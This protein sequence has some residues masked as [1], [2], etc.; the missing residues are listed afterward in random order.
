MYKYIKHIFITFAL[1]IAAAISALAQAPQGFGY[2]AVVRGAD[3]AIVANTDITVTIS[4]LQGSA[5]GTAVY[6][7]THTTTTNANGLFG[8]VVGEGTT[9]DDFSAIDWS[10]G[11]YF[12]KVESEYGT[13]TTQLLSVP[14][15][16]YAAK[17]DLSELYKN[18]DVD[19][20]LSDIQANINTVT[21]RINNGAIPAAFSV[22]ADKKICF[23]QGNL[24]YQASTGIWRFAENQWDCFGNAAGNT[25]AEANRPTQSEWIDLFGWGTSGWNSGANTYM[26]YSTNTT[27][28]D[29][30]PGNSSASNLTGE[31]AQADWGVYNAIQNG[32]NK[33]GLW[34]T[35]TSDE[36]YYLFKSRTDAS[37]KY[38]V[39]CVNGVNGLVILPDEWT[40]PEGITFNPGYHTT[41]GSQYFAQINNYS[42]AQWA[43]MEAVGAVFFP[44]AGRR[45]GTEVLRVGLYG[46][47]WSSS[48]CDERDAYRMYFSS[49]KVTENGHY[50][51]SNGFS[52]RLIREL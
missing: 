26:P 33:A 50:Y 7:E 20:K 42:A 27:K 13:S 41:E 24:Q 34:R 49:F 52:V 31:Y 14:Y 37:D 4:I 11:V 48:P 38:G 6:S 47:Y 22:A 43:Q 3:N 21:K 30:Y 18:A 12:L 17:T 35:L 28:S 25:T 16:M 10:T 5:D 19:A 39:A 29:Y 23:S 2:Q 9:T 36:W 15:A 32:G 1:L 45:E 46:Y 51:R 8:I 40:Q 44:T